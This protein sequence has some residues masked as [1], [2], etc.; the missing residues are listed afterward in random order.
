MTDRVAGI[1]LPPL[2]GLIAGGLVA[3]GV[4]LSMFVADGLLILAGLGA[5]GPGVL[6]E[7]GWLRDQDEFQR[8]S[9]HRAGYIAYL[10]GGFAAVLAFSALR[11]READLGSAAEWL[12]LILVIMWLT[13][14]FTSMLSYWGARRTT[15]L[16]L[17]VFGSFWAVFVGAMIVGSFN[18]PEGF[19]LVG[20]L[21][22]FVFVAPFFILAWTAARWPEM[23]GVLLLAVAAVF[24]LLVSPVWAARSLQWS[25]V[26][27]TATLL[28]VPLASCGIALLKED[29]SNNEEA[30][31]KEATDDVTRDRPA[32]VATRRKGLLMA[33]SII[34]LLY[35]WGIIS[36]F[37]PSP[38]GSWVSTRVPYEPPYP[39]QIFV[40]LLFLLFLTG[41]LVVWKSELIG[42]IIFVVYWVAMWLVE[43]F[44]FFPMMGGDAGGGI[45]MGFPV[46]VVGVLFIRRW[47]K[48]RIAET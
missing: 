25:S 38:E 2:P 32:H 21:M 48:G 43:I 6:R 41:Y 44:V 15:A 27:L 1:R 7:M 3:A 8:R 12:E 45:A 17:R 22:A 10:I 19:Q 18:D 28:V 34:G 30:D 9:A 36:S 14:L 16:V 29:R 24:L 13:W 5:F 46:F 33:T 40:V 47:H 37:I 23:T 42:G 39:E 35:L 11:W 26:L 31:E 4:L 20:L